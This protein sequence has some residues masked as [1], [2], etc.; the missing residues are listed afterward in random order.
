MGN[1]FSS[2]KTKLYYISLLKNHHNPTGYSLHGLWPNYSDGTYPS[3]CK[4]VTFDM[5]LL[6]PIEDELLQFWELPQDTNK[7]E[8]KFW[9]HEYIK[10]GSCMFTEM[11]ELEYFSK[12]LELYKFVFNENIDVEKYRKGK[13]YMIPFDVDFNL[14]E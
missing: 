8:E 1:Y 3:F 13:N 9:K 2:N 12:A 4:K 10:H 5:K 7:L 14:I 11:N 6:E